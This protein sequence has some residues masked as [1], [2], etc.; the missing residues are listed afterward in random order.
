MV[1]RKMLLISVVGTLKSH[2]NLLGVLIRINTYK[3]DVSSPEPEAHKV[4]LSGK[5]KILIYRHTINL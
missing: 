4:S 2:L 5:A 1:N 3:C